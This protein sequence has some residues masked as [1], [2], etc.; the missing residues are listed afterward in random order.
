MTGRDRRRSRY[1][2]VVV[3]AL[4]IVALAACGGSSDNVENFVQVR[5]APADYT[6]DD[7]KAFGLK[8]SKH[9]DV[10]GLPDG[11]DAWKGFWGLDPYDRHDYEIRFYT[12]HDLAVSSGKQLAIDATGAEFEA[13]RDSQVWTEGVKDRW[14]A[15]GVTDVSSGGS[16]QAPGPTYQDWAI[17]GNM[18]ILCDGL[19]SEQA[20]KRCASLIDNFLPGDEG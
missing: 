16:R 14:Q 20:L 7:L 15:R 5:E 9:Y 1:G 18:V 10:E 2:I 8:A 4:L 6:I 13:K 3:F 19:D 17:V 11:L 12:S